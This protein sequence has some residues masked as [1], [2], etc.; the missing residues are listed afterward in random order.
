MIAATGFEVCAKQKR[1]CYQR[2][3]GAPTRGPAHFD[4]RWR[5]RP[6]LALLARETDARD[7]L[8][9]LRRFQGESIGTAINLGQLPRHPALTFTYPGCVAILA[10]GGLPYFLGRRE[11]RANDMGSSWLDP[12]SLNFNRA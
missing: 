5:E 10:R 8:M 11:V 7:P 4:W 9:R 6:A 3:F 12:I 2:R 1:R